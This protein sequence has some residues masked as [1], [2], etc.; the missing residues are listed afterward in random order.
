MLLRRPAQCRACLARQ[1]I[2]AL[3]LL[4]SYPPPLLPPPSHL[5]DPEGYGWLPKNLNKGRLDLFLLCLGGIMTLNCIIFWRVAVKYE[6]KTV[7]H[8]QR[9]TV[10]RF[11]G[12][13]WPGCFA[14]G[15]RVSEVWT[16]GQRMDHHQ[17]S[18]CGLGGCCVMGRL[19][20][21]SL[22]QGPLLWTRST[23]PTV[24]PDPSQP[25]QP[26]ARRCAPPR[27]TIPAMHAAG[28]RA[29][30]PPRPR[31]QAAVRAAGLPRYLGGPPD[32][33]AP[34][35]RVARPG[36]VRPLGHLHA[37]LA[38]DAG[39]PALSEAGRATPIEAG[40]AA[41]GNHAY[42]LPLPSLPA[43]SACPAECEVLSVS[44]SAGEQGV[45]TTLWT[46]ASRISGISSSWAR[47]TA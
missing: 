20:G 21:G 34:A 37:A 1:V 18:W 46:G 8:V 29:A 47:P 22:S 2:P 19:H 13:A 23:I 16:E 30:A 35:A 24:R 32:P 10:R 45:P 28:S 14:E 38:G 4:C 40:G 27:L 3:H 9:V 43:S 42:T 12:V 15:R 6:Y 7:E 5:P 26:P 31:P 39:G 11:W 44:L 36:P 41:C 33:A 25:S 17:G